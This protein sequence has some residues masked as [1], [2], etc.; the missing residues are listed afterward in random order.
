MWGEKID[1]KSKKELTKSN[2]QKQKNIEHQMVRI[3]GI[4]FC[5]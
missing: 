3:S 1:A 4:F 2:Q 5:G